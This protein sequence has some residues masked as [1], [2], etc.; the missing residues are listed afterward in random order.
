MFAWQRRYKTQ[1][2]KSSQNTD[3]TSYSPVHTLAVG[4]I[5]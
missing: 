2:K 3:S 1:L 4:C 5:V